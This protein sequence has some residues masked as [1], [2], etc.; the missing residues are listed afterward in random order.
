MKNCAL[1]RALMEK[2]G[3]DVEAAL[4]A[5]IQASCAWAGVRAVCTLFAQCLGLDEAELL[6][7]CRRIRRNG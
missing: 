2:H 7:I 1:V 3:E 5:T 4:A 6:R